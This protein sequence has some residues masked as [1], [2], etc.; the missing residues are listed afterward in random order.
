MH[1]KW[2]FTIFLSC[3]D[4]ITSFYRKNWPH[5]QKLEPRQMQGSTH[6]CLVIIK[7]LLGG[8]PSAACSLY[9]CPGAQI[10]QFNG[11]ENGIPS[12]NSLAQR[13]TK[14][15]LS[16]EFYLQPPQKW[17]PSNLV[18]EKNP[19]TSNVHMLSRGAQPSLH[20]RR[21]FFKVKHKRTKSVRF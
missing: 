15:I 16:E 17:T 9:F 2:K 8:S 12:Q 19:N 1:P 13:R 10:E 21:P 14:T 18:K 5:A 3:W 7:I 6:C 20:R 4:W 11:Y